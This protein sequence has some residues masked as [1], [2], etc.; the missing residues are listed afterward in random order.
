MAVMLRR[1]RLTTIPLDVEH[2]HI[3]DSRLL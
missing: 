3:Q 1:A 2:S